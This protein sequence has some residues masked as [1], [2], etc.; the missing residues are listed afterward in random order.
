MKKEYD[1]W[2]NKHNVPNLKLYTLLMGIFYGTL[3]LNFLCC[4]LYGKR[5]LKLEYA[6]LILILSIIMFVLT[7]IVMIDEKRE[8][9]NLFATITYGIM[10]GVCTI[11]SIVLL[12]FGA[13]LLL[14]IV[15]IMIVI[16]LIIRNYR[17]NHGKG[18]RNS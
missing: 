9:R 3:G 1:F 15:E 13:L 16:F 2:V 10:H 18:I 6:D 8:N 12:R 7:P 5:E 11:G 14:Y 4:F 17:I